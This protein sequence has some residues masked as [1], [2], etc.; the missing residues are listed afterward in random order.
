MITSVNRSLFSVVALSLLCL[1][2]CGK[3]DQP[4]NSD[5]ATPPHG[6]TRTLPQDATPRVETGV[7]DYGGIFHD[8]VKPGHK[9]KDGDHRSF[10][11]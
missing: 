6:K 10:R 2:A 3:G 7:V 4:A 8:D 9:F 11:P 5:A 1:T